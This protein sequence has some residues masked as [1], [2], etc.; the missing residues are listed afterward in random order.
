VKL[1]NQVLWANREAESL[2]ALR[3]Q[4][5]QE[6]GSEF[7]LKDSLLL[8]SSRLVIPETDLRTALIREAH[9]QVST[10]HLG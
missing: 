1:L 3:Q 8:Y 10:A 5:Q 2:K 4:A 7:T 6:E 9:D